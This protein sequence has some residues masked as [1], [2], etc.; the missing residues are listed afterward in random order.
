MDGNEYID[1]IPKLISKQGH[2]STYN[3]E[4]YQLIHGGDGLLTPGQD[5]M[6]RVGL[7]IMEHIPWLSTRPHE[8][9][10]LKCDAVA[11][12]RYGITKYSCLQRGLAPAMVEN[13][14]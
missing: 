3:C 1:F 8:G 7:L 10:P 12:P 5:H 11:L 4:I 14:D 13:T 6:P 9:N 2:G